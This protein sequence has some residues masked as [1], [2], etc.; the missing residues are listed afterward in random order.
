MDLQASR[1]T[2]LGESVPLIQEHPR[3][4]GEDGSYRPSG[5][6]NIGEARI[7]RRILGRAANCRRVALVAVVIYDTVAVVI[8]IYIVVFIIVIIAVVVYNTILSTNH[9]KFYLQRVIVICILGCSWRYS[10][11]IKIIIQNP[12]VVYIFARVK[13]FVKVYIF[14]EADVF[15]ANLCAISTAIYRSYIGNFKDVFGIAVVVREGGKLCSSSAYYS[16]TLRAANKA[17][18]HPTRRQYILIQL[19]RQVLC[20]ILANSLI[21]ISIDEPL[22]N[23]CIGRCLNSTPELRSKAY[24]KSKNFTLV[25]CCGLPWITLPIPVFV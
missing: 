25:F 1:D 5:G 7:V 22:C 19:M 16:H 12:I 20:S 3:G 9:K 11:Y 13:V 17:L 6:E 15:I 14:S 4:V 23:S 8:F 10:A 2:H 21:T 18:F 24:L